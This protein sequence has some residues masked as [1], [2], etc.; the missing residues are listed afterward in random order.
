[1]TRLEPKISGVGNN[2]S[3]NWATTPA[4]P[5]KRFIPDWQLFCLKFIKK[6]RGGGQ[7]VRVL[8][9]YPD[10]LSSNPAI[11][12]SFFSKICFWKELK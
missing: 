11:D 9:F 3:T 10:Y 2:R 12:Y 5:Y 7:V 6:G 4:L 1:M 8:A